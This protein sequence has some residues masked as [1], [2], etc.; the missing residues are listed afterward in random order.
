MNAFLLF[1]L[2]IV[3]PL[4]MAVTLLTPVYSGVVGAAYLV[5]NPPGGPNPL[6]QQLLNLFYMIDVYVGLFNYWLTH[7]SAVST[8]HYTLPLIGLP[9]IGLIISLWITR[10]TVIILMETARDLG[11]GGH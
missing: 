3:S 7:I 1:L 8:L 5:Y 10:K 9:L 2:A 4:L 11:T 6:D